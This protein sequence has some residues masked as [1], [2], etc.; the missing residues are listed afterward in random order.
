MLKVETV[1]IVKQT[2]PLIKEN[3]EKITSRMYEILFTKYP[4]TKELFKN[5]PE[6]QYKILANAIFAYASNVDKVENL[7]QAVEKMAKKHVETNVK[8][9]HYPLVKDALLKSISEILNP[10]EKVLN[11][12]EEAYDF[13]ANVLIEKE[14]QLYSVEV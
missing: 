5:A 4:E 1:A 6:N 7:T 12:W 11:A 10:P 8:P 2:A 14:K 9:E 13:L 3:G